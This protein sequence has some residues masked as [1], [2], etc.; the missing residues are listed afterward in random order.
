MITRATVSSCRALWVE[1][2]PFW[3][4]ELHKIHD[5]LERVTDWTEARALQARAVAIRAFLKLPQDLDNI[6]TLAEQT[7]REGE[8]HG[9][10]EL[11]AT[12]R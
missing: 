2:M 5:A 6:V 7:K 11:A 4:A 8:S 10:V 1:L 9:R 12:E 3:E